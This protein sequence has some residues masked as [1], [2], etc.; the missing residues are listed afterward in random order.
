MNTN[1]ESILNEHRVFTPS[2]T[3][4][5][6][7]HVK[8]MEDYEAI[9]QKSVADPESWWAQQAGHLHWQQPWNQ[10][11]DWSNPP[12]A[13]WFLGGKI[14]VSE[15]CLDRHVTA[16]KGDRIALRWEGE[17]GD[18]R[19]ISYSQLLEM[20]CRAAN[21]LKVH[22][23]QAGDR[24]LIYMPM[25]PEAAAA[26]LACARIGAVHSVVFG[27]FSAT[28]IKDRL[29]DSK[30]TAIITADGGWRRGN[31]VPLK[32]NVDEALTHYDG[33]HTVLVVKRC[34]NEVT[35]T[36]G[37]DRWWDEECAAVS[38]DCPAEGFDS[39]HPLYI[40]YTSGSTGKPKG[41]LHTSGGYLTGAAT[42]FRYIFDHRDSDV[43]WCTADVGWVTGHS[44]IV[45]GP[46]A[47]GATQV[48]YEGAPNTPDWDRF[49]KIIA[50]HKVTVFYTAPTA[51]RAFIKAGDQ[52]VDKHD[53][54]SLRLLGSVGEPINPE[55]WIWYHE[56]IGAG[57]CPIV[58]TWWQTE[59]G[60][61]LI[62][63]IPGATPLKPGTATRPFFGI[64]AAILDET[65]QECGP[66]EGGK[67]VIRKPWPS[68]LR[69]LWGDP[70]RFKATYWSEYEGTYLAGDGARRDEDGY[71][72]IV[73]RLDDVL[74]VS[75][76]RLGT[77]EVE[78]ALV[79]HPA[80]AEA[81]VVGRPDEIKGQGVVA[82]V[83]VKTGVPT[84]KELAL[85]LRNHVAKE[86]GAI[87]KP[88][89]IRFA[90]TLPKTRSGKIMRRLLK[91]IVS[92][93]EVKGDVTTL[94]DFNAVASLQ[95]KGD[96]D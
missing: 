94:E 43:F 13:Q 83:T 23:V 61:I 27:G 33:I 42:T 86:I 88:D 89:D 41:I 60:A 3:F 9:Y 96:E 57:R 11:L 75:G 20:V 66:N 7:A 10:I 44:Y 58:D 69:T 48:M 38:A 16:G 32:A 25:I 24:V 28:A 49:W 56:K 93:G 62:S 81:A 92:S 22:G 72:W 55:A 45:Y 71:F 53:L 67:L 64:D 70:E 78:S 19:D 1:I 4:S 68:M 15:N 18:R 47:N 5:G 2:A 21:A 90:A 6:Q 31:V 74:N 87:A 46:M 59:T 73:G 52:H 82:F 30:A 26:M 79:S 84:S 29:E 76:H 40:L 54:S 50:D 77:A 8:S 37:R 65:G 14:N 91:E 63:P 36:E 95:G 39:E 12:F 17:P 35:M 85:E 80:V 34:G 51:I